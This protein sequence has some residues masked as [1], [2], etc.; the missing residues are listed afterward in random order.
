MEDLLFLNFLGR[1]KN[2]P[3]NLRGLA[4]GLKKDEM[5][6]CIVGLFN[7]FVNFI[8]GMDEMSSFDKLFT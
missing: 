6:K 7:L 4:R 8:C 2:L 5:Y 3:F 1:F